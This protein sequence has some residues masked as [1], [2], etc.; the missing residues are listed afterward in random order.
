MN[1]LTNWW[2]S[3]SRLEEQPVP[4]EDPITSRSLATPIAVFSL[5]LILSLF[6]ALYDEVWGLRPWIN[7]QNE[8]VEQYREILQDRKPD[9]REEEQQIY[10][11]EG[12]QH[13]QGL[14][15]EEDSEIKSVLGEI[16]KEEDLVLAKLG[17]TDHSFLHHRTKPNTGQDLRIGNSK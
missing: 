7:Y 8:F 14:L 5:L 10:A 15:E 2:K 9:R 17:C 11:S 1:H 12:Y 16:V 13:L 3:L 6:W 4:E